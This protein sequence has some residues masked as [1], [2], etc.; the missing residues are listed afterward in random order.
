M[1]ATN[2]LMVLLIAIALGW[3][4]LSYFAYKVIEPTAIF[5]VSMSLMLVLKPKGRWATFIVL[6]CIVSL[7][8]NL[9]V[10][11]TRDPYDVSKSTSKS[12][13]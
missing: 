13:D 2:V 6:L 8:V 7:F 3:Q 10:R 9:R 12:A 5:V 4:V 11:L 1:S